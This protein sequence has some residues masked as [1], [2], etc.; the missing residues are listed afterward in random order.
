VSEREI[1]PRQLGLDPNCDVPGDDWIL[2]GIDM[3]ERG[4]SWLRLALRATAAP[5]LVC[6]VVLSPTNE[7][8]DAPFVA[9]HQ[10]MVM[11]FAAPEEWNLLG[12]GSRDAFLR[13]L[14]AGDV[15][16]GGNFGRF[17]RNLE[18]LL[19]EATKG[20]FGTKVVECATKLPEDG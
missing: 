18:W 15:E 5:S 7:F 16:L 11:A 6:D 8:P 14:V 9:A 17:R 10:P 4:S 3:G 13:H 19:E 1:D 12:Q 2:L 20:D